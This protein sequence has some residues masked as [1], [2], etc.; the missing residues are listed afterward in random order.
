LLYVTSIILDSL[1]DIFTWLLAL[2]CGEQK[3]AVVL[4]DIKAT[5]SWRQAHSG[6]RQQVNSYVPLSRDYEDIFPAVGIQSRWIVVDS[7]S[8][9]LGE[10][11]SDIWCWSYC[12]HQH[13]LCVLPLKSDK[14]QSSDL[15]IFA[16]SVSKTFIGR[17]VCQEFEP[18]V[19]VL[20]HGANHAI[21]C[22]YLCL[23][24]F[25]YVSSCGLAAYI[26]TTWC[27]GCGL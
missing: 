24:C 14:V 23:L 6:C 11:W 1:L 20:L 27:T 15:L 7:P 9:L 13:K 17:A 2:F 4:S 16:T 10:C 25:I 18:E 22:Y 3:S 21:M 5:H 19:P 26:F 8:W 12:R